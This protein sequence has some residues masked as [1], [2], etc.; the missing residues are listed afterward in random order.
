MSYEVWTKNGTEKEFSF[1]TVVGNFTR[2]MMKEKEL[3]DLGCECV[4]CIGLK[5]AKYAS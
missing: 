5:E 1:F 4:L 3:K 2:A